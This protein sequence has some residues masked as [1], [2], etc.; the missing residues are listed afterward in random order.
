[1]VEFLVD[2]VVSIVKF[3]LASLI[4]MIGFNALH[5]MYASVPPLGFAGIFLGVVMLASLVEA[6]TPSRSD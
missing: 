4:L 1:M 5:S 2:L 3:L 6:V